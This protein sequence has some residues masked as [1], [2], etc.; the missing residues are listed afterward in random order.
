MIDLRFK[1]SA[2][3]SRFQQPVV[4][5]RLRSVGTATPPRRFSQQDVLALF[6]EDDPRIRRLF[7][8]SHIQ[9][10]HL[11]LPEPQNGLLPDETNQQLIDKHRNGALA[12][13]PEAV[14]DCL[15]PL[16]L[17]PFDVDFLACVSST[18]FLCPG[19]T[20]FLIQEMGFRPN[21][22]RLDILGMGCNAAMNGLQATTAFA[23]AHPG[24]LG[25][26][27]CVE[28]CSAAYVRNKSISTAVVNSLFGD[29]C[30]AVAITHDSGDGPDDGPLLFDF[31]PH[32]IT[33]HI[34]AMRYDLD[35]GKLSFYLDRDIPYVIGRN[36]EKPVHR[37]LGRH[38]LKPRDIDHWLVHSG[39]KKVIDAIEYNLGL[40]DHDVRHTL[41][42]LQNYGNLSSGSILFSLKELHREG[43]VEP[44]DLGVVIA[45][46]PGTSIET[47]LLAW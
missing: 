46:G 1:M 8:N 25:L 14:R 7:L 29:G 13:G 37:L 42:V 44:G 30:A 5:P 3:R 33:D 35:G 24:K 4:G 17:E 38:G 6:G 45:M 27:V 19:L 36:V 32:I 23:K 18:G 9:T 28:I 39:G 21:V 10:R 20:A 41:H 2:R 26:M 16:G 43:V 12:I 11:F 47:G 40:T 15:E 31:E 34:G 22:R